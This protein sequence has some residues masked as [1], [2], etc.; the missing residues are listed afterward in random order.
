MG[1]LFTKLCILIGNDNFLLFV[2][3]FTFTNLFE[4]NL[5]NCHCFQIKL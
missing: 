3:R 1:H 2:V 4:D 5:I